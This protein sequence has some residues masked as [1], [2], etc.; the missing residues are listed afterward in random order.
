MRNIKARAISALIAKLCIEANTKLRG[1]IRCAICA[2]LKKETSVRAK[3]YLKM[4]I[5]NAG[6]AA[7]E[8]IAICQDTGIAAVFVDMGQNAHVIGGLLKSAVD[9]GVERGYKEGY[10]RKSVVHC[11]IRRKNTGTNTPA[12]LHTTIVPGDSF[13]VWVMVKGFG[14]EN[15]S[16]IKMLYPTAGEEE[17][18]DFILDTVKNAGA[19]A[20][21]PLAIGIGMGGTFDHAAHLAK[22]S[23]LRDIGKKNPEKYLAVLEKKIMDKVNK[24]GIGPM[25]LGGK[26]TALGVTIL[27]S[28]THI[29]GLP[30]AVNISCHATRSAYGK[31]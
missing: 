5:D 20:C 18:I 31:L 19:E 9:R 11:P 14:S 1:D 4:L 6:I 10:F 12:I 16:V 26:T 15:K 24:L 28:A 25:G 22:R 8:G 23:L 21:P 13:K 29:A 2:A 3:R 30:V 27:A 17:I 7:K